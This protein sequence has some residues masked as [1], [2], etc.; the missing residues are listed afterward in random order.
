[1]SIF[2]LDLPHQI[3]IGLRR[4]LTH[5]HENIVTERAAL[6]A[7]FY[8]LLSSAKF[9]VVQWASLKTSAAFLYNTLSG[10][11]YGSW[12]SKRHGE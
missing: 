8:N 2:S 6:S 12:A 1:M 4:D 3:I 10:Q 11:A 9:I 5:M 7:D